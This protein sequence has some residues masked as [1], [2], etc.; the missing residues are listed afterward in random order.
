MAYVPKCVY[1]VFL[2]YAHVDNQDGD[3]WVDRFKKELERVLREELAVCVGEQRFVVWQDVERLKPGFAL[4]QSIREALSKT[5]VVISLYSPN[6]L[7]SGYCAEERSTFEQLC[8]D[9]LRIG[10]SSRLIN[11]IIRSTPDVVRLASRDL[12]ATLANNNGPLVIGSDPFRDQ[13]IRV[14]QAV[15]ALLEGMRREFPKVYVALNGPSGN[16]DLD[17]RITKATVKL[18]EDLSQAGYARTTEIHPGFYSSDADIE[19]EIHTAKV[20]VH[21][22]GQPSDPLAR[23]QIEAAC[24]ANVPVLVWLAEDAREQDAEWIRKTIPAPGREYSTAAFEVFCDRVK[25]MLARNVA[26]PA[27]ES[28]PARPKTVFLLRNAR[29]PTDREGAESVRRRLEAQRLS[30]TFD[31]KSWD[32]LDG[33]LVYQK[34]AEDKWFETKLAYVMNA[35]VVRAAC[36]IP[37]PDKKRAVQA[38]QDYNFKPAP[39]IDRQDPRLLLKGDAHQDLQ[40]F[41]EAVLGR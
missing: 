33:V 35:P 3:R 37:P 26:R 27:A 10:E 40:P 30:V 20:S 1:D 38:A 18:L 25:E 13:F 41:V 23:R 31:T 7:A 2:S 11:V 19:D 8:G 5:A 9:R 21:L 28:L 29:I 34:A 15:K 24:R 39:D 16:P 32:V 12:F 6:Y 22:V 4:T 14:V 36:T 17:A